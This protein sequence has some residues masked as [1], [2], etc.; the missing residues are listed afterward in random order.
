MHEDEEEVWEVEEIDN[1]RKRKRAVQYRV[2]WA[3]CTEFEDTWETIDHLYN[4]TDKLEELRQKF[5]RKPRD[6][7]EAWLWP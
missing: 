2:R 3:L 1:S 4:W 5:H 6:E 7:Q